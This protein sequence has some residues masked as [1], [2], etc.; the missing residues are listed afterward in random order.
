MTFGVFDPKKN[1]TKFKICQHIKFIII[2][3]INNLKQ[4][5]KLNKCDDHVLTSSSFL[6]LIVDVRRL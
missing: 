3:I 5:L 6:S 2:F 4:T 1:N